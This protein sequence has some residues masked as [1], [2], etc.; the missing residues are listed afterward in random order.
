MSTEEEIEAGAAA[1]YE[2]LERALQTKSGCLL[3]RNGTI[4]MQAIH[5]FQHTPGGIPPALA[6]KLELHAGIFPSTRNSVNAWAR[7]YL[8]AVRSINQDP[9]VG[10]WYPPTREME[11]AM[12]SELSPRSKQ[13][14]LRSLEPYYVEGA[15]RW[16]NL[17]NGKKVCVVTSF[18]ETAHSQ[19]LQRRQIWGSAA[20]SL[21]PPETEWVF[22]QTG[23]S[24]ALAHG[25][26]EWPVDCD[27]WEDAVAYMEKKI[28]EEAP[29]VCIIGCGGLGMILGARCKKL[30]IPTI[31]LGGA[32]QV[33]FGI[34]GGRWASHSVISKFWNN[35][36]VWPSLQETPRG[37]GQIEAAC[38]W[39]GEGSKN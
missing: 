1:V 2:C 34:K 14:P 15:K 31:L 33:L 13:I 29:D 18:A 26:A 23:Y 22:V 19:I 25:R 5:A 10:G 4:E 36:W 20:D 39:A 16:T 17:L 30:R 6:S 27:G 21:L 28:Q 37:A 35:A 8:E 11:R 9:V 24:P 38:Y 3:G 7:E 32:T 12:F